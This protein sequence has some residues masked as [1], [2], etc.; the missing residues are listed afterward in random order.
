MAID[1]GLLASNFQNL[2]VGLGGFQGF[3][4]KEAGPNKMGFVKT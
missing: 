3:Q 2:E 1:A 4:Q